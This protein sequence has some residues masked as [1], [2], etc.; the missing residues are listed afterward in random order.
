MHT[1]EVQLRA[2]ARRD[3]VR[4][5]PVDYSPDLALIHG[6]RRAA[7]G[8]LYVPVWTGASERT[9][10]SSPAINFLFRAWHDSHHLAT[11][12]DFELDAERYLARRAAE[13]VHGAGARALMLAE[14]RGQIDYFERWG[15]FPAD[16]RAFARAYVADPV[17]A[18]YTPNL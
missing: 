10:W 15:R 13:Q 11:G 12:A 4:P 2:L 17:Q 8:I 6:L 3:G 16:Q 9:I 1:L 5:I 18:I 7:D 14:V